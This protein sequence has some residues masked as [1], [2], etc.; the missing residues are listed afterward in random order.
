[1]KIICLGDSLTAGY[2]LRREEN[3]LELLNR[4]T[5]NQWLNAGVSGDTSTG[6]VARLSAEVLPQRPDEV[7]FMGGDND[8]LLTGSADQAKSA[9]MAM[10]HQCAARGVRPVVG[11]AFP[12]LDVPEVWR[13][14]CDWQRASREMHQQ[15]LWLRRLVQALSL[16][17]VDFA[18]A[19]DGNGGSDLYQPDG[20]HPNAAGCRVMADAVKRAL[21]HHYRG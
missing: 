19:F 15:V 2:N 8:I 11:I 10:I 4:K 18:A 5:P 21:Y 17:H 9:V 16:R 1:M 7:L 6:L 12:L 14:V 3:W 13:P 20:M